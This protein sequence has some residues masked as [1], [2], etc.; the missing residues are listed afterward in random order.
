MPKRAARVA[1]PENVRL[2]AASPLP[3]HR[4]LY[5]RL[6]EGILAGQIPAGARLPSTRVL[7]S[8]LG[9]SRTTTAATYDELVMEGYL[10]SRVGNGTQV[11]CAAA[12]AG[13]LHPGPADG[14]SSV[15]VF[16][17]QLQPARPEWNLSV[18]G[19]TSRY[20]GISLCSL[21]TS[22]GPAGKNHPEGS[23]G[24]PGRGGIPTSTVSHRG[25]HH[26]LARRALYAGTGADHRGRA[27]RAGSG[28][29]SASLSGG[30]GVGG[31]S[32]L[33]RGLQRAAGRG[34]PPCTSPC[35]PGGP[36]NR[37]ETVPDD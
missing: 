25:A 8:Y 27:G 31:K 33:Q 6:R 37:R 9:V 13:S 4:Q 15:G 36:G 16:S 23:H 18:S 26:C 5:S 2:D 20:R 10:E 32:R 11:T 17:G 7:A 30:N 22:T 35:R 1:M 21:G 29:A 14:G 12:R 28:G 34:C 24:I 19:G 3:L